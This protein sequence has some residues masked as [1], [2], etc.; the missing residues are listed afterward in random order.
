M[1]DKA[2]LCYICSWSPVS[3]HVYSL[4][5]GLVPRSSGGVKLVDIVFPMGLQSP[6]APLVLALALPLGSLGSV[7][8]LAVSICLCISQ[9]LAEPLRE[10]PYQAPVS[11]CFL[12]STI[13]SGFGTCRWDGSLGGPVSVWYFLQSLLHFLFVWLFFVWLVVYLCPC[14]SLEQEQFWLNNFEMGGWTQPSTLACAC[15]YWR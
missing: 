1:S 2:I 10:H 11:K 5:G 3:L 8:W 4:G 13:V 7:Q 9:V 14:L 15:L 6:S 12:A